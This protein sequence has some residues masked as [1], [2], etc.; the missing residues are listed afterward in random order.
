MWRQLPGKEAFALAPTGA[1]AAGGALGE[2]AHAPPRQKRS[3]RLPWPTA[4]GGDACE[5]SAALG[6]SAASSAAVVLRLKAA[7]EAAPAAMTRNAWT[8]DAPP[9]AC[10]KD[11]GHVTAL[12]AGT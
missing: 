3:V 4:A 10:T 11:A 1:A 9:A 12:T 5:T 2:R 6:E 8:G 7:G